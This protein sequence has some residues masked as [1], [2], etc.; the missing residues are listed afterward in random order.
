M[1][2]KEEIKEVLYNISNILIEDRLYNVYKIEDNNIIYLYRLHYMINKDD[3]ILEKMKLTIDNLVEISN[4][5]SVVLYKQEVIKSN[6]IDNCIDE[7][8]FYM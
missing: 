1:L 5:N 7:D 8:L 6:V 4:S 3:Y 2:N